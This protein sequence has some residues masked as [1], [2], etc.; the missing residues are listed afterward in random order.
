M[1]PTKNAANRPTVASTK[2]EAPTDLSMRRARRTNP[3]MTM[4]SRSWSILT[5]LPR[6]P[7]SCAFPAAETVCGATLEATFMPQRV[8][9]VN[10]KS[11]S[12][13]RAAIRVAP[14]SLIPVSPAFLDKKKVMPPTTAA[15]ITGRR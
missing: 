8:K 12:E 14:T 15:S 4:P 13:P 10:E 2:L 6:K 9:S 3:V 7:K 1:M 5:M 11:T